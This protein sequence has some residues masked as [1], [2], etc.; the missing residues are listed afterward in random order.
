M[1]VAQE[2]SSPWDVEMGKSPGSDHHDVI[3]IAMAGT[4]QIWTHFLE[5]V[6]WTKGRYQHFKHF[7]NF[8]A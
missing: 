6:T 7:L 2:I 5:D 8:G 1:G 4:H 3:Y